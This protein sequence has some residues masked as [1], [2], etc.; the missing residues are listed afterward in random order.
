MALTKRNLFEAVANSEETSTITEEM[1][2]FAAELIVKL[3]RDNA[4]SRAKAK[5]KRDAEGTSAKTAEIDAKVLADI[6]SVIGATPMTGKQ[7]VAAMGNY[8]YTNAHDEKKAISTQKVGTL[9]AK[10]TKVIKDKAL[11]DGKVAVVYHI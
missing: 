9:L 11:I 3:D 5:V 8:T 10:S 6:E 7:V 2:A 4:V 1:K